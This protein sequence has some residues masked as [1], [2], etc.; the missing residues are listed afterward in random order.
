MMLYL[1]DAVVFFFYRFVGIPVALFFLY[2]FRNFLPAKIQEMINDRDNKNLQAL[3]A[4]PIWIHAASGEIEYAKSLIREL[5]SQLPQV[6]ILVTY[7]SPS[8]KK[9]LQKFPG[10]DLVRAMPWD[11]PRDVQ[12]FLSFYQPRIALFARTDVWPEVAHEI[13]KRNIP[14]ALF[15]A[16]FSENSTRSKLIASSLTRTA[17]SS[18]SRIFCV[19]QNDAENMEELGVSSAFEISGDT[20]FDQVIYRL[21]NPHPVKTELRPAADKKVLILG[22]SWPQDEEVLIQSFAYWKKSQGKII[23]APHEVGEPRLSSL[24]QKLEQLGFSC[25]RYS[26][27]SQWQSEDILLVD[28]VGCLH[29]LYTWADLAFVGGS[30][31][32]KVHSVMEPLSAGIQVMV[33]PYHHNNREALQFQYLILGPGNFAVQ[34]VQNAAEIEILMQKALSFQGRVHDEILLKVKQ[35]SG[36][37]ERLIQWIRECLRV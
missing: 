32:D 9:L 29:E 18:L 33:G 16:T 8:A 6:P 22:S 37:T 17:L 10:I 20:R 30:F 28:Q 24:Q 2:L 26:Q 34:P 27:A 5:K 19:S 35:S 25:L 13:K 11:N 3:S 14:S 1:F 15:S 31:K 36:A 21:K 12:K 7:F 4:K 23:L